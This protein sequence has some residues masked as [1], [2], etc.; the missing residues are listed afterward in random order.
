MH[1]GRLTLGG[2]AFLLAAALAHATT[3]YV[4][5]KDGD[6]NA[7]GT[8]LEKPWRTLARAQRAELRP[9]D[10]LLLAA[11]MRHAGRL[12]F[13]SLR[14]TAQSPITIGSYKRAGEE[15]S[16]AMIDGRGMRAALELRNCSYVVVSDLVVSAD[17]GA[18]T[19]DMRCGVLVEA[20]GS[21]EYRGIALMR[22]LVKSVS[23]ENPGYRR[24][25][26]DVR[27]PNGRVRYGWGI[28][29]IVAAKSEA[30]LRDVIVRDC[31]I[32]RVDHTGLKFTAPA[33]GIRQV[34]VENVSIAD[35]GGPG[36]QMSGVSGGRFARLSVD[37]SGSTDDT[38]NWG[39][40][41]GLWTWDTKDVVIERSRFTNANGPGDSAGVHIDFNCQNVVVQY[42]L[43]A[44]NAGGFCEILGNNRN[45]AYRYNISVNDGHRVKGRNG[46]FQEG[47]LFWL[48]GY[49]GD[50]QPAR[51]PFNSYFYN[52]TIYVSDA[53]ESK[54]AIAPTAA[55]VLVAN[56]IFCVV[57]QSRRV[58]GDQSRSDKL[59]AAPVERAVMSHNLFLR[60]DTWPKDLGLEDAA[61]V[62]GDPAF[63]APGGERLA[64][65]IPGNSA[66]V[67]DRGVPIAALRGDPIGLAIGLE[68]TTDILGRPITGAPDIGAIELP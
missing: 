39:R 23:F 36:I 26:A 47:K 68:V 56:N 31:Q 66:L 17:G 62:F 40:G 38:R 65:Y 51:G 61:P 18:P 27:T 48:S 1:P 55:G 30:V 67:K 43:S 35:T 50:K 21:A 9:G 46:A 63:A 19:G 60:E 29:F 52:N 10:R 34:I 59:A 54:F 6:D 44:N 41:S 64:D 49:V 5:A 22:L 20:D 32:E 3:F 37:R 28:R 12:Y 57:G 42:N 33:D 13:A 11:G 8:S 53:I 7:E 24:P 4:D 16:R 15:H 58:A 45:C 25:A 2:L 14:G